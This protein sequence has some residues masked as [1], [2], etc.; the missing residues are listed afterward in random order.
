M[1]GHARTCKD[2]RGHAVTCGELRVKR[3]TRPKHACGDM[4]GTEGLTL[5]PPKAC[6]RGH[7]GTCGEPRVKRPPAQKC[8]GPCGDMPGH[9]GCPGNFPL[10]PVLREFRQP[11]AKHGE[12]NKVARKPD[13]VANTVSWFFSEK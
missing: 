6:V 12:T 13:K 11:L 10:T 1:R 3:S 4:R 5:A 9:A 2:M 8:A 7:A